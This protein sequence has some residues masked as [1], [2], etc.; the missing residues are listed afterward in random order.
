M[1]KLHQLKLVQFK[2]ELHKQ[3]LATKIIQ[4]SAKIK[5]KRNRVDVKIE[6]TKNQV[7]AKIE[8][9]AAIDAKI[10]KQL[11]E[12][13]E[14]FDVQVIELDQKLSGKIDKLKQDLEETKKIKSTPVNYV[15]TKTLKT[16]AA[17]V[18]KKET[19]LET[20]IKAVRDSDLRQTLI[21]ADKRN[22]KDAVAYSLA[23]KS[24]KQASQ[25]DKNLHQIREECSC[26]RI[27]LEWKDQNYGVPKC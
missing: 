1:T 5:Q 24:A 10:I 19:A 3:N 23:F 12:H 8:Q 21:P 2:E 4:Q 14:K 9:S 17:E 15:T 22:L 16:P 27:V 11:I 20:F 6:Q 7:D 25:T 26:Q 18:F 13:R